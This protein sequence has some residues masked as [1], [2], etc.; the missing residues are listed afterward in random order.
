[1]DTQKIIRK[2][3]RASERIL[4]TAFTAALLLLLFLAV[5]VTLDNRR[6]VTNASAEVYQSYKPTADDTASFDELVAINPDV[7]GWLT[8][9]GTNIDY[10][11]VQGKDNEIYVNTAVNGEFSL[12]GALFLDYRNASDF[13]DPI[14][15]V[16]G[17]NMTGDMMFGGIDN[18]ADPEYFSRHL[19]GTLFY[20][21]N[22]YRL[23]IFAF[24]SA[25]GHDTQVYAPH[26]DEES[27]KAWLEHVNS[28]AV[29]LT[30]K[31][32]TG[33]PILLMSTCSAGQTNA[34]DLL[35]ATISPG[36]KAPAGRGESHTS[37]NGIHLHGG[38]AELSPWTFLTPSAIVLTGLTFLFIVLKRR[39]KREEDHGE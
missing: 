36:G 22:Y 21:G 38:G 11:L 31:Q 18:Y 16:Y 8:V 37:Q 14:S 30:A 39:K 7:V 27:C 33:G 6:I 32:P 23:G 28:I 10:P 3:I 2:L 29:S 17:H 26:T 1:M 25:D 9:D 5:Y 15:I 34:R 20:G 4:S 35:A 13:T 24:F 19:T 12:S